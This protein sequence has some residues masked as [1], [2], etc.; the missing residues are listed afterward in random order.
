M[1]LY[2]TSVADIKKFVEVTRKFASDIDLV[3]GHYRIDA[4]SIMGVF[5]IDSSKP[6]DIEMISK[7]NET[8]E[9]LIKSLAESGIIVS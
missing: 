4:K 1:R 9:D 6:V 5:S 7:N 3:S 8:R 2:L